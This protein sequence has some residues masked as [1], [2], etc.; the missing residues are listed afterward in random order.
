MRSVS[1]TSGLVYVLFLYILYVIFFFSWLRSNFFLVSTVFFME[2][3]GTSDFHALGAYGP[4]SFK[5]N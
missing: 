2:K 3:S 1:G 4:P 5:L